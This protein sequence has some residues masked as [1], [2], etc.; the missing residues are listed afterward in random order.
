MLTFWANYSIM[1]KISLKKIFM[2]VWTLNSHIHNVVFAK[3]SLKLL[4]LLFCKN[5]NFSAQTVVPLH[6]AS[7]SIWF[8]RWAYNFIKLLLNQTS[9]ELSHTIPSNDMSTRH[10][11]CGCLK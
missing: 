1:L 7:F 2:A 3:A 11:C 10:P 9:N 8:K 4:N 5:S 6:L